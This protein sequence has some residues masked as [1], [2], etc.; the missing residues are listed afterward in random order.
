MKSAPAWQFAGLRRLPGQGGQLFGRVASER[1][2]TGEERP[3]VGMPGGA[4]YLLNA[5]GFDN[6]AA[7]HH[8]DPVADVG[9]GGE[10]MRDQ[11]DR[12][13]AFIADAQQKIEDLRLN[14]Y[15]QRGG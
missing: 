8:H 4:E 11:E 5:P 6:P 12:S 15:V 1:Q 3:R 14:G 7:V 10:I 9:D 2:E 13:A